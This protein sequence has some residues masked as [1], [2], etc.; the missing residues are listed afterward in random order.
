MV[1]SHHLSLWTGGLK[2]HTT[3]H[4]HVIK[5]YFSLLEKSVFHVALLSVIAMV[6]A[7]CGTKF[8]SMNLLS[9][10]TE[11]RFKVQYYA[12]WT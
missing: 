11:H 12:N 10:I 7:S 6:N 9:S 8:Y 4:F 3:P 5:T 2:S 1:T